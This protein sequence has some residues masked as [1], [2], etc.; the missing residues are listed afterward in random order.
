VREAPL[1]SPISWLPGRGSADPANPP[2]LWV[3]EEVDRH[4]AN[5][6]AMR[7]ITYRQFSAGDAE[8]VQAVA[9]EAWHHAYPHLFSART[10]DE[11]IDSHYTPES[12]REQVALIEKGLGYFVLAIDRDEVIGFGDF[13]LTERE[14]ELYRLYVRPAYTGQGIGRTLLELGEAF[15][16]SRGIGAYFCFVN[17]GNTRGQEFYRKRGFRHVAAR[18]RADVYY[19]EKRLL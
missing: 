11:Y 2:T 16:A 18:D 17:K 12:L 1:P 13:R 15:L 3:P 10:I 4:A 19:L 14:A 6:Q 8:A 5:G 7:A 9:R